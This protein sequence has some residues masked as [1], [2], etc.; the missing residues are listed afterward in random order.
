M[1]FGPSPGS[2]Y[3]GVPCPKGSEPMCFHMARSS[4]SE[5]NLLHDLMGRLADP[6]IPRPSC[7][8]MGGQRF[9]FKWQSCEASVVLRTSR[10][11][12]SLHNITTDLRTHKHDG[13]NLKTCSASMMLLPTF[14]NTRELENSKTEGPV[15]VPV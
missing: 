10:L 7:F 5:S 14:V 8:N 9:Q 1:P 11:T 2:N 13:F 15:I 4:T 12:A 6:L 3:L